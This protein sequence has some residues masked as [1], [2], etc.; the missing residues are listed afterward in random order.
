MISYQPPLS[1]SDSKLLLPH[2]IVIFGDKVYL[3]LFL[4]SQKN[5]CNSWVLSLF[6]PRF[7]M[8]ISQKVLESSLALFLSGSETLSCVHLFH[9]DFTV[10]IPSYTAA[11]QPSHLGVTK[12]L[13]LNKASGSF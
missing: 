10:E 13:H 6:Y 9:N 8:S 12:S 7:F 2:I 11:P 3:R 5:F 1:A 4:D